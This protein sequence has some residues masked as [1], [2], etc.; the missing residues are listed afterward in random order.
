MKLRRVWVVVD[1]YGFVEAFDTA[2]EARRMARVWDKSARHVPPHEVV[3]FVPE[4]RRR[5]A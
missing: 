1:A 3:P 5:A 2:K 4:R